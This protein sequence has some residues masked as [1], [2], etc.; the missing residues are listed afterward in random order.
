[1]NDA[2]H[3]LSRHNCLNSTN[4]RRPMIGASME[5]SVRSGVPSNRSHWTCLRLSIVSRGSS[6]ALCA[7]W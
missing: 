7:V 5:H 4:S 6:R 1:V 3:W 2:H